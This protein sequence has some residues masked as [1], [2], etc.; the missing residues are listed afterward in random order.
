VTQP[1]FVPIG[2][3]DTVRPAMA[4]P[5]ASHVVGRP[6]EVHSPRGQS[7]DGFG[8][9]GP[10]QGYA[11]TLAARMHDRLSL[12]EGEHVHDIEVG[13]ALLASRRAGMYGRAPSI[14]DLEVAAGIFGFLG[15]APQ[16]LVEFRTELFKSLGHSYTSQR[17]LCD[18]VPDE[19][20][21]MTPEQAANQRSD[22]KRIFT[23]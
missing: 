10:D 21:A 22:W 15:D 7:G 23:F 4:Q 1:T 6:S 3:A 2:Q 11:L 14:Y 19:S 12:A 17:A 9:P 20:L 18:R 5:V 13:L 8:S 16:D